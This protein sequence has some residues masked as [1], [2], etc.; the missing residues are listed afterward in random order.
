MHLCLFSSLLLFL[1]NKTSNPC[2]LSPSWHWLQVEAKANDFKVISSQASL[3]PKQMQFSQFITNPQRMLSVSQ[4]P[5]SV[6]QCQLRPIK[7]IRHHN[8]A[9]HSDGGRAHNEAS[10]KR[11]GKWSY[12]HWIVSQTQRPSDK[13]KET[14]LFLWSVFLSSYLLIYIHNPPS[15]SAQT[16]AQSS[17]VHS[18]SCFMSKPIVQLR[19][20]F[21]YIAGGQWT[22]HLCVI[23]RAFSLP[24]PSIPAISSPAPTYNV[25]PG[26]GTIHISARLLLSGPRGPIEPEASAGP[27]T[28]GEVNCSPTC[29]CFQHG[30]CSD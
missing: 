13:H 11:S 24:P 9:R 5:L 25:P 17:G 4:Q 27:A 30:W 2:Y 18:V 12:G 26:Q 10:L 22:S 20:L 3:P 15:T 21:Q 6:Y 29:V 7:P 28:Q 1:Y 14:P 19:E 23:A 8:V 16:P